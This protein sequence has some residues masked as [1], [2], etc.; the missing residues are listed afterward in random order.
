MKEERQ[1]LR[2]AKIQAR[3]SLH[4]TEIKMH[5][6]QIAERI[7]ASKEFQ[8]AEKIMIY[9]GIG[10]EVRLDMLE[11]A[12]EA[13]GKQFLF[14]LCLPE[15][16][17]AALTPKG[18]DGWRVG[19]YGI[20]EPVME[21]SELVQPEDIDVQQRRGAQQRPVGV[22]ARQHQ[23]PLAVRPAA[24][25]QGQ[26]SA[27]GQRAA[28]GGVEGAGAEEVRGVG[29]APGDD[30]L[31]GVEV[32]REVDL[33][34]VQRLAAQRARAFVAGHVKARRVG[35]GVFADEVA[36]GGGGEHGTSGGE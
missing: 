22:A 17:M 21:K 34:D 29:L 20:M 13:E 33:G 35:G 19:S 18:E 27:N 28:L 31:R 2:K 15:R 36:D 25:G 8:E 9:R 14:P 26:H 1:D 11:A 30:A 5:S 24:Q 3:E 32:V 23:R 12:K 16:Q 4:T 6:Q 7:L 10:G